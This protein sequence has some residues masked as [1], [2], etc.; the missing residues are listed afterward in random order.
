MYPYVLESWVGDFALIP[1]Y[2]LLLAMAYT[3]AYI[4]TLRRAIAMKMDP[5]I[6]E[7]LFLIVVVSSLAGA[8]LFHVVI[9]ELSYY[10]HNPA[11]VLAVWE[12]GFTFYGGLLFSIGCIYSYTR[13]KKYSFAGLLDLMAPSA[14]LGLAIGR[15]GCL[16]AGCCWGHSTKMPW[17]ITYTHLQ[18]MSGMRYV[19][20]HPV[21]LYE[22]VGAFAIYWSLRPLFHKSS[23][24][25]SIALRAL[26]YYATLRFFVEFFRGDEYRGFVLGGYLSVSQL[27]SLGI[28]VFCTVLHNRRPKLEPRSAP[29]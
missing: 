13:Y 11:D 29:L 22:S 8:R 16:A 28:L 12:G 17:G 20:V 3:V 14:M 19:P 23:P 26:T 24:L 2:G 25:G 27:I 6:V 4:E 21:Q 9:E 18:T 15:L 7:R 5:K 10:R 1:T